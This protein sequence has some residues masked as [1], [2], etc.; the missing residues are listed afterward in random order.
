MEVRSG[1]N[2]ELKPMVEFLESI[3]VGIRNAFL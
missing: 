3:M 2:E 1:G